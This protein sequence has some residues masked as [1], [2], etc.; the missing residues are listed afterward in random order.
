VR[1]CGCVAVCIHTHGAR[2][3]HTYTYTDRQLRVEGACRRLHDRRQRAR[4]HDQ[5]RNPQTA[6]TQEHGTTY[7]REKVRGV[8]P[9]ALG[10]RRYE[11]AWTALKVEPS[12]QPSIDG[13][14]VEGKTLH[15]GPLL[16]ERTCREMCRITCAQRPGAHCSMYQLATG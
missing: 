13:L 2:P 15:S 14:A 7:V 16:M 4:L 11:S 5:R 8:R 6:A 10:V 1:G 9:T 3:R 12:I